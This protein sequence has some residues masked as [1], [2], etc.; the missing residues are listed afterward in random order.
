MSEFSAT[1][2]SSVPRVA[3]VTGAARGIGCSIANALRARGD[4]VL[5]PERAELDLAS[6]E[7]VQAWLRRPRPIVDILVNNAG[8]NPIGPL[9]GVALDTWQ[10]ALAVN[11]TAPMLL[12]QSLARDMRARR[13]GR[14]VNI[15]SCY[16]LATRAGRAPYGAAKAGLNSLTRSAALEFA[17]EGVLVNAVCPGFVETDLTRRNNTPEQIR[18]L[19]AQV[20]LGRLAQPD[21]VARLVAFL[22]SSENTYLTG[23]T[24]VIDG[25]FLLQ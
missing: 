12:L 8:E 24:L 25:G 20:P 5:A 3:L 17:S 13:W 18:A 6:L 4:T 21:E 23:Q 22:T 16:S 14:V 10:R 19:A 11:L 2:A 7:S 1:S 9:D 15:S